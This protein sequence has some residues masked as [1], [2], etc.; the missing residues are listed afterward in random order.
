MLL[1]NAY[2]SQS[3]LLLKGRLHTVVNKSSDIDI[4]Y[5][6]GALRHGHLLLLLLLLLGQSFHG[7][8]R[9][10]TWRRRAVS[11]ILAH[12]VTSSS[13][14]GMHGGGELSRPR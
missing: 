3:L 14:G 10:H 5:H 13:G 9:H 1:I 6:R 2:L 11:N 4:L 8:T 7:H 12:T